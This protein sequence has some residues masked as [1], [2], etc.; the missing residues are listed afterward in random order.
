MRTK[1]E[2]MYMFEES[3]YHPAN[4]GRICYYRNAPRGIGNLSP[5]AQYGP[6]FFLSLEHPYWFV[7]SSRK[8]AR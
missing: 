8:V 2:D 7:F 1:Y 4:S 6:Q 5:V 3:D